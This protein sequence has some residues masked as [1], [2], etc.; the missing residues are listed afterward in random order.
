MSEFDHDWHSAHSVGKTAGANGLLATTGA[1]IRVG[2]LLAAR[3]HEADRPDVVLARTTDRVG[4]MSMRDT[5][6]STTV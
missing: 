2:D 3:L 5:F 4:A 1:V 6:C